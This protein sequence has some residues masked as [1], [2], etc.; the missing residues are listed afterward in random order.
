MNKR[1]IPTPV[2]RAGE[3]KAGAV[4]CGGTQASWVKTVVVAELTKN[5]T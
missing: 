5:K 1:D 4:K 3:A 2:V